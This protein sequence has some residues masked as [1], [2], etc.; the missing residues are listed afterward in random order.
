MKFY[1][2]G[3]VILFL[4]SMLNRGIAIW[5]GVPPVFLVQYLAD[6]VLFFLCVRVCYGAAF[7]RRFFEPGAV[8]LIYW[9]TMV[10]G[11]ASTALLVAGP[12]LGLPDFDVHPINLVMSFLPYPMFALP[13][14]LVD[15]AVRGGGEACGCD[16]KGETE[17]APPPGDGS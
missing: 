11:F 17:N 10:L 16:A 5:L 15:R 8:R 13:S 2:F 1:F 14:I 9:G 12:S 4:F 7:N 3:L 6:A